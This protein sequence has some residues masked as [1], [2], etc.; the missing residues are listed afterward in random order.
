M[1]LRMPAIAEPAL[2]LRQVLEAGGL[3]TPWAEAR[4]GQRIEADIRASA[5]FRLFREEA[6]ALGVPEGANWAAL[7]R[8]GELVQQDG[9]PVARVTSIVVLSRI[10]TA[11]YDQLRTTRT[12]LGTV[13]GPGTS[14][15]VS[16]CS[17]GICEFAVACGRLILRGGQAVAMTTD[18]VYWSW[19]GATRPRTPAS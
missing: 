19:L 15:D 2:E 9:T 7:R 13:L 5:P 16:W 10:T 6:A 8:G 12:P 1:N 11:E 4:C 14:S 3:L 18:Q 17:E